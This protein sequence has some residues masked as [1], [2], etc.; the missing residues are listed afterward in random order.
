MIL[1]E[2]SNPW[3]SGVA[4][5]FSKEWYHFVRGKMAKDGIFVQWTQLYEISDP[6]VRSL[7]AALLSEFPYAHV[8]LSNQSDLIIV[9]SLSPLTPRLLKGI[10]ASE[11][12]DP[13]Y[14]RVGLNSP[15]AIAARYI[16]S[17]ELLKVYIGSQGFLANS[18]FFPI[19]EYNAPKTFFMGATP[20]TFQMA[21]NRILPINMLDPDPE[22]DYGAFTTRLQHSSAAVSRSGALGLAKLSAS[23]VFD[24]SQP[25]LNSCP[26]AEKDS[27]N[28]LN[29]A[30]EASL[31]WLSE[32]NAKAFWSNPRF[33]SCPFDEKQR[34][35]VQLIQMLL[36]GDG[37]NAQTLSKSLVKKLP[38]NTKQRSYA[39]AFG[40]LALAR[41]GEHARALQHLE[42]EN[43][44]DYA[45]EQVMFRM[46][47]DWIIAQGAAKS[48]ASK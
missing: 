36:A 17:Q 10:P 19:V 2:P 22:I 15:G 34:E 39:L 47:G 14:Q 16:G 3:V 31:S 24:P 46:M 27:F 35:F 8:Y 1:S 26:E 6:L 37:Q 20:T 43:I 12:E 5:L 38:P 40:A 4:N 33:E 41:A 18:D 25:S 7:Q 23:T 11:F 28:A 48:A 13:I 29:Q 21:M 32:S 9:A 45:R 42:S 44:N 30:A